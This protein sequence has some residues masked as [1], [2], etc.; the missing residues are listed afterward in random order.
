MFCQQGLEV[1]HEPSARFGEVVHWGHGMIYVKFE[2][3]EK[4]DCEEHDL[5]NA[6]TWCELEGI[7]RGADRWWYVNEDDE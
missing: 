4:A 2:D 1:Y 6:D 5:W 3:G 7:D